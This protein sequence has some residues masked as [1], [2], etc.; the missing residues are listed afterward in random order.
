M[1][2]ITIFSE[3]NRRQC[4]PIPSNA[5]KWYKKVEIKPLCDELNQGK[6]PSAPFTSLRLCV[7]RH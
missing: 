3:V 4:R 2:A 5:V 6:Q 1:K 7:L